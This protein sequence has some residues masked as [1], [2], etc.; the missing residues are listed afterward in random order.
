MCDGKVT[1]AYSSVSIVCVYLGGDGCGLTV[2][3]YLIRGICSGST[4]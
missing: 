2:I 3:L 4:R 1:L